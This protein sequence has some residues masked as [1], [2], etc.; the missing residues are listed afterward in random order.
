MMKV[1]VTKIELSVPSPDVS[2]LGDLA[3]RPRCSHSGRSGEGALKLQVEKYLLKI[4]LKYN[5]YMAKKIGF[6]KLTKA[7]RAKISSKGGK[8]AAKVIA[9]KKAPVKVAA[10][11]KVSAK[12]K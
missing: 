8:A 7:E 10:K 3:G 6:A 5:T 4:N 11:A 2:N 1:R 12:K 9:A